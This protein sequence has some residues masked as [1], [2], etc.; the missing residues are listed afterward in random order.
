MTIRAIPIA[1]SYKNQDRGGG[2]GWNEYIGFR[3]NISEN[4]NHNLV[5]IVHDEDYS[6]E[7]YYYLGI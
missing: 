7:N 1:L 3:G 6:R 4:G 2:R 5:M